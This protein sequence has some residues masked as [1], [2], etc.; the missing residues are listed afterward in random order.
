M[1]FVTLYSKN[2]MT[3][4]GWLSLDER[5]GNVK[6]LSETA[7][8]EAGRRLTQSRVCRTNLLLIYRQEL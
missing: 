2:V 3:S 1:F 7:M 8:K 5:R 6:Y 4:K